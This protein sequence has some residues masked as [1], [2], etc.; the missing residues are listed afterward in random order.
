MAASPPPAPCVA[1]IKPTP[2]LASE[3]KRGFDN[4]DQNVN[5]A[6]PAF[7]QHLPTGESL[8][9]EQR[10]P[11]EQSDQVQGLVR[12]TFLTALQQPHP[13]S[14]ESH[15]VQKRQT[16]R[17]QQRSNSSPAEKARGRV[18]AEAVTGA[19]PTGLADDKEHVINGDNYG[20]QSGD[21]QY[22]VDGNGGH[23]KII[24]RLQN[25]KGEIDAIVAT[26][27]DPTGDARV[28][29]EEVCKVLGPRREG[30]RAPMDPFAVQ[31][32]ALTSAG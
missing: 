11:V 25:R 17:P 23:E 16:S 24:L 12:H 30:R 28:A 26:A 4:S 13:A 21:G 5:F 20:G 2:G 22:R 18:G 19:G 10:P 32:A 14:G 29:K 15:P 31:R 6:G 8:N 1:P 9:R 7:E 27:A 3:R